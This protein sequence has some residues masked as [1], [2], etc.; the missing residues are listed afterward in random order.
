VGVPLPEDNDNARF[1]AEL[2]LSL[3]EQQHDTVPPQED[4]DD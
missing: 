1:A 3:F 4:E 2:S